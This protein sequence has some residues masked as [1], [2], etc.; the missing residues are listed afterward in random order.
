MPMPSLVLD[1]S[2]EVTA[3][4][5]PYATDTFWTFKHL[6]FASDRI[7]VVGRKQFIANLDLISK[8]LDRGIKI[9]YSNPFEGSETVVSILTKLN[10]QQWFF[11]RK[12]LLISGG[13][14]G[15]EWYNLSYDLFLTK[16]HNYTENLDVIAKCDEIFTKQHKPYKFLFLNGRGRAHRKYMIE[17]LH[18]LGLLD[19][20]LYTW[21]D[22]IAPESSWINQDI[23]ITPR[24]IHMLPVQYEVQRY[25]ERVNLEYN[26][27]DYAMMKLFNNE[28]GAIYLNLP[29][30]TDTYFSLVTE[31][32][33]DYPFSF[34]TEKIWKPVA[35]GHPWVCVANSG[36]Y[37]DMRNLG[38][39]TFNGIIDEGFDAIENTQQR[40]D[41]VLSVVKEICANPIEFLDASRDIC[42]YNQAHMC[43]LREKVSADFPNRFFKFL[44]D[45]QW[46]T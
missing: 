31:T 44:R 15:L 28:W 42:K 26:T 25:Q 8:L 33:A 1:E 10:C 4:L 13:D 40:L 32:V 27:T 11:D 12:V 37:R 24:P 46:T 18:A 14:I 30:Y 6:S 23:M 45:Y 35:I 43:A 17:K 36:F 21:L 41:A 20:S 5:K 22:P 9:V 2:C 39:R 3:L 16:V 34:R 29:T 7:Y 19:Q 38:F